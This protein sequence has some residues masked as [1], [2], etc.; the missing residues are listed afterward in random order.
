M[1]VTDAECARLL[2][3][4]VLDGR[5]VAERP[6]CVRY[7]WQSGS[8]TAVVADNP[9][10]NAVFFETD[11]DEPAADFCVGRTRFAPIT[12]VGGATW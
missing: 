2:F 6:G 12:T 1:V 5:R 7:V 3:E 9:Q 4:V 10:I 11:C 8:I